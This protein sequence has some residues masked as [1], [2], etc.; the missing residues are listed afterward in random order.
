MFAHTC[1]GADLDSH[2]TNSQPDATRGPTPATS[3]EP[4]LT[5]L[6]LITPVA[7]AYALQPAHTLCGQEDHTETVKKGFIREGNQAQGS[8]R[9]VYFTHD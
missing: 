5:S 9:Q 7:G 1:F 4:I 8:V 2:P 3:A 6:T